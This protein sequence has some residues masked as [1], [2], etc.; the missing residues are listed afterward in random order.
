MCFYVHSGLTG[1]I[2]MSIRLQKP[3][4]LEKATA[5]VTKKISIIQEILIFS[6]IK[7]LKGSVVP[8]WKIPQQNSQFLNFGT[9]VPQQNQLWNFNANKPNFNQLQLTNNL[10]KSKSKQRSCSN[11]EV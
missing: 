3:N 4:K 10:K 1:T 5:L 7:N 8:Q 11:A 9:L 2:A 6:L